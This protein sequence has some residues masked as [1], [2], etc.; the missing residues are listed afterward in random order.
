M[1]SQRSARCLVFGKKIALLLATCFYLTFDFSSFQVFGRIIAE[2]LEWQN[3]G[4]GAGWVIAASAA[5]LVGAQ[6]A[7]RG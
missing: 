7:Q 2:V 6:K 4:I 1:Q 5:T 3:I